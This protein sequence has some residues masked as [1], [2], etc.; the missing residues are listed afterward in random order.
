[1]VR[2]LGS[3]PRPH[4][5]RTLLLSLLCGLSLSGCS[6]RLEL[7]NLVYL[8]VSTNSDQTID[9]ELL[10]DFK[11]RLSIL[12]NGY[13]QLHPATR[14]QFGVYREDQINAATKRRNR[15]GLGPD[16]LFINGDTARQL[17][18]QGLIDPFPLDASLA[19][20]FN[21]DDLRRMRMPNGA[22]AGLPI[23]IQPQ[24][25]CY[26]R[27]RMPNPPSTL[28]ELLK[29]SAQGNT[30]G[31]SVDIASLFWTAGSM[32]A[33]EAMDRIAAGATPTRADR[34]RIKA[35]L[36]WLQNASDQQRV[37]FH[38][39]PISLKKEFSAGRLD[40]IN[41]SSMSLPRL[42]K[43]LGPALGVTSLPS[44]PGGLASPINRLRVLALGR[45]SSQEGRKRAIAFSRFS[46]NPLVQRSLTLG[47]ETLLPA[48][49]FVKVPLQSSRTLEAMVASQTEGQQASTLVAT[50]HNND[51]RITATQSVLTQLVF[52]EV[53]PS[54][55]TNNLLSL[56][57]NEKP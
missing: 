47:S 36:S 55:A 37:S 45:S 49:R 21:P 1:M 8:T 23:M 9:A 43:A 18:D 30:V 38:A 25:A 34:E 17:L 52:G 10:D 31:L 35:W 12:E 20:L 48:N 33:V 41:C 13:R 11:E 51:P 7:P 27:K 4:R 3:P 6:A 29:A 26:N 5:R 42:R 19:N 53:S 44:G 28:G 57:Q 16:L 22:L 2:L 50:L 56:F 32:G 54:G 46:V 24:V 40:W 39:D 15:A 14:F